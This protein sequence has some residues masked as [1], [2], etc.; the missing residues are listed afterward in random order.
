MHKMFQ[1][2]VIL[3]LAVI[4]IV[5][6][7]CT[8]G[9]IEMCIRDSTPD[10]GNITLTIKEKPN[11]F[12]LNVLDMDFELMVEMC[13]RDRFIPVFF[14]SCTSSAKA[15]AVMAMMGTFLRLPASARIAAVA[16]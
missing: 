6:I 5:F 7:G 9:S 13:I 2:V 1:L 15:F 4:G 16:S 12:V 3:R 14:A 10:G 11:G 8:I